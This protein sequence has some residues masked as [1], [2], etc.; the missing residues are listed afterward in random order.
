[1]G[2]VYIIKTTRAS[3][4]QDTLAQARNNINSHEMGLNEA[5]C[6]YRISSRKPRR[7]L[8]SESSIVKPS[9]GQRPELGLGH[10]K[11]RCGYQIIGKI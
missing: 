2:K 9:S 3:F 4:S 11:T 1:M 10:E 7:Y 5:S 8:K 6:E